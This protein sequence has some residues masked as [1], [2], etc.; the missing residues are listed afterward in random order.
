MPDKLAKRLVNFAKKCK[1]KKLRA[2]STYHSLKEVLE[3]YSLISEGT[4]IIPFFTPKIHKIPDNNKHL[5]LYMANIKLRQMLWDID[6]NK[7]EFHV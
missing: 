7:F 5:K 4:E 2:F 1:D 3:K 6:N